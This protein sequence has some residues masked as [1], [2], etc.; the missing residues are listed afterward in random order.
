MKNNI[1]VAQK[2]KIKTM[3]RKLLH[4][5]LQTQFHAIVYGNVWQSRSSPD[6]DHL[7]QDAPL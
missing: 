4:Y 7:P 6:Y 3:K 1:G 5:Q 2:E